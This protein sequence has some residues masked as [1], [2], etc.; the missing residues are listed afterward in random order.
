VPIAA[1]VPLKP[2]LNPEKADVS[3]IRRVV[4]TERHE[5]SQGNCNPKRWFP[6]FHVSK[7][8]RK[9]PNGLLVMKNIRDD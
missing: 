4:C 6:M 9:R 2:R 8:G 3:E 1:L 5:R 7:L